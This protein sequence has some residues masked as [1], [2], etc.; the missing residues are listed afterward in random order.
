MKL[1]PWKTTDVRIQIPLVFRTLLFLPRENKYRNTARWSNYY[2]GILAGSK[3]SFHLSACRIMLFGGHV[4][5]DITCRLSW[6]L[7]ALG[8][9]EYSYQA[10][11]EKSKNTAKRLPLCLT[12]C[13]STDLKKKKEDGALVRRWMF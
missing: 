4:S 5:K 10:L 2:L 11:K 9:T 8:M 13:I 6:P 3:C 12:N 7:V 1:R